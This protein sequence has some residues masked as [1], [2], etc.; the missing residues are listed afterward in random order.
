M[1]HKSTKFRPLIQ[2]FFLIKPI[3]NP[4]LF[5]HNMQIFSQIQSIDVFFL[6][7]APTVI[8]LM[9]DPDIT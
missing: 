8:G 7:K 9:A 6:E 3:F 1:S 5:I 2:L 4:F